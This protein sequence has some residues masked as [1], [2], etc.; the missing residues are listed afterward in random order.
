MYTY[1]QYI[2]GLSVQAK[3]SRSFPI[4]SS[5]CYNS[6]VVTLMVACLTASKLEPLIFLLMASE[7]VSFITTLH[8]PNGKHSLYCC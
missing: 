5:S 7:F 4:I 2:Q 8:R 1:I 3:Y 6:S